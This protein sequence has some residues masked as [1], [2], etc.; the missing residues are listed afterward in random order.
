MQFTVERLPDGGRSSR[1]S[2]ED[3]IIG[4][5]EQQRHAL[6]I[7]VAKQVGKT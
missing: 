4:V 3:R 7:E 6:G 1:Q 5:D 2:A